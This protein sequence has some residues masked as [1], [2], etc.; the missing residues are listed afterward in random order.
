M[1]SAIAAEAGFAIKA[2]YRRISTCSAPAP[3]EHRE[4]ASRSRSSR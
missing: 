1:I 4:P 2:I 3:D